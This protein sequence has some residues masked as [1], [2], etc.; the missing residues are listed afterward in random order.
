MLILVG[1]YLKIIKNVMSPLM[2]HCRVQVFELRVSAIFYVHVIKHSNKVEMRFGRVIS[3]KAVVV[4]SMSCWPNWKS[5]TIS[6][7]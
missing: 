1:D 2:S 4:S 5:V 7:A 6:N 3:M